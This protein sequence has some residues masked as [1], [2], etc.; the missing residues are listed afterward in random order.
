LPKYE[1]IHFRQKW[2]FCT[3]F[4]FFVKNRNSGQN[5]NYDKNR[6]IVKDGT[7]WSKLDILDTNIF[8]K[9]LKNLIFLTNYEFFYDL[10]MN[11]K[12]SN[13]FQ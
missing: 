2:Q 3:K 13:N 6:L 12:L 8:S 10:T 1:N 4:D 9:I 5:G 11:K 7:F